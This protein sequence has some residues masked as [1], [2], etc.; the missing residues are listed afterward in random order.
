MKIQGKLIEMEVTVKLERESEL[1]LRK[2]LEELQKMNA[3]EREAHLVRMEIVKSVL[4]LSCP[5]CKQVFLDFNGCF[6]LTCSRWLL[7][8]VY[9]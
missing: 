6:A 5:R 3:V 2:R 8:L 9:G 4:N 1:K 7:C